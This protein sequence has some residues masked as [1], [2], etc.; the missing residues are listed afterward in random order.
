MCLI[1]YYNSLVIDVL[2]LMND[3]FNFFVYL[4]SVVVVSNKKI[5]N[6]DKL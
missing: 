2:K 4:K 1:R 6:K 3:V 5:L